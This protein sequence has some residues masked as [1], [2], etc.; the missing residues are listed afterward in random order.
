[1]GKEDILQVAER[2]DRMGRGV[3]GGGE[4]LR[5]EEEEEEGRDEGERCSEREAQVCVTRK[6]RKL[7][8]CT[9]ITGTSG[10]FDIGLT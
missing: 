1:M 8:S 6:R 5:E 9:A 2:I 7:R 4:M 10:V 3:C